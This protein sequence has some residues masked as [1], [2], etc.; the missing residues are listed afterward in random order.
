MTVKLD[1]IDATSGDPVPPELIPS[2]LTAGTFRFE[3]GAT[4][5]FDA[6]GSTTYTEQGQPSQGT[7]Y[8]EG[9]NFCSFWPPSFTGCYQITWVVES[10]QITG[11]RF[12]DQASAAQFVGRYTT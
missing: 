10:D 11:L 6:D 3:N 5:V 9:P 1:E 12:A 8:I 4:Q 7:W 2:A